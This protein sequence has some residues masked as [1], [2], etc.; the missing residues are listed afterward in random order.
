V[1]AVRAHHTPVRLAL[2]AFVVAIAVTSARTQQVFRS[3]VDLV[4]VTATVTDSHGRSITGLR[5]EDFTVL[6]DGKPVEILNFSAE[7]V[8]ISLGILLDVSGS[9]TPD[10]LA[11]ARAAINRFNYDLLDKDDELFLVTFS[12]QAATRQAW[13]RDRDSIRRA[14]SRIQVGPGTAIY[15][16]VSSSL[17]IAATGVHEKKALLIVSDGDDRNSRTTLKDLQE[18]IRASEV[19]VYALGVE[20]YD[21]IDAGRLRKITDDT[22][23]RTEIVKGFRN[24]DIATAKLAEELNQQYLLAYT[25][26]HDRDGHEHSIKV[27]VRKRGA[28]VRARS[29]YIAGPP[30]S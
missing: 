14:L 24:L 18:L 7:R 11:A 17:P 28:R 20:G 27:E 23:G 26:P 19:L 5:K 9:M 15:D 6:D 1:I 22:G 2:I 10:K 21:K 29:G 13:T 25:T 30:P 4:N 8:P 16:A 3:G 12:M